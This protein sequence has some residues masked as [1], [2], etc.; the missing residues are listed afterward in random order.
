[1]TPAIASRRP[2]ICSVCPVRVSHTATP[3]AATIA[4]ALKRTHVIRLSI[5]FHLLLSVVANWFRSRRA[6]PVRRERLA[7]F[8]HCRLARNA[9]GR[10][11]DGLET[12]GRDLLLT[13]QAHAVDAIAQT[14]A[15]CFNF[16]Q[17]S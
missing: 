3:V 14:F 9:A 13:A 1:M 17:Q 10:P 15:S 2:P 12:L 8:F 11:R 7:L 5:V 6:H 4:I 16:T